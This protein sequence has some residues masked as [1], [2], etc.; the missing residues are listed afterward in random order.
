MEN[1]E[2]PNISPFLAGLP[3]IGKWMKSEYENAKNLIQC[4]NVMHNWFNI[5]EETNNI[6]KKKCYET[7]ASLLY[8]LLTKNTFES[9]NLI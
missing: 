7:G 4:V 3:P 8:H 9:K 5:A 2:K 6:V 1:F